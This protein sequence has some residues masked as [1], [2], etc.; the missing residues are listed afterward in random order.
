MQSNILR[1]ENLLWVHDLLDAQI[2]QDAV[3][4]QAD[5]LITKN[6]NDFDV[7]GIYEK[8]KIKVTKEIPPFLLQ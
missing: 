6:L 8:H 7:R 3:D 5:F 2:L 4:I 1:A